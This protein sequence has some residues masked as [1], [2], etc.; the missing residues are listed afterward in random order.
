GQ[1]A[2][3]LAKLLLERGYRVVGTSRDAAMTSFSNL[4]RLGI[5][6]QIRIVSATLT[7]FRSIIRVLLEVEPD[8]IYNLSGQTSVGLSFEQP[9]EALES[10]AYGTLNLL[11]AIRLLR[12]SVR[13]YNAC[14]SECFGDISGE[15]ADENTPFRP[16]SP[17]GVAKAAAF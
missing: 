7:D 17:Y 16:H 4:V 15:P 2:A 11:E 8:E 5:R 6:D 14:S 12:Q 9:A 10:I 1:D 3:W 13:F